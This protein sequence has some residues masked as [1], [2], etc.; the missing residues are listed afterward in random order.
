MG[1]GIIKSHDGAGLYTVEIVIDNTR[2][3]K[4]ID[5]CQ[6]RIENLRELQKPEAEVAAN[7]AESVKNTEFAGLNTAIN[8]WKADPTDENLKAIRDQQAVYQ[9]ALK[10]Y[11]RKR[12]PL[13]LIESRILAQL[14]HFSWLQSQKL[15]NFDAQV[16]SAD[17]IDGNCGGAVHTAGSEVGI[18]EF[19][20]DAD[21][22]RVIQPGFTGGETFDVDRDGNLMPVAV[23]SPAATYYNFAI[24]P[25]WQKWRYEYRVGTI[26]AVG[27]TAGNF[28]VTLDDRKSDQQFPLIPVN[29]VSANDDRNLSDIDVSYMD[30]DAAAF[31]VGDRVVVQ[32][33]KDFTSYPPTIA[34][35]ETIIGFET[36]PKGCLPNGFNYQSWNG[37][38]GPIYGWQNIDDST[39][40]WV[41][42]EPIST[43]LT[44]DITSYN[45]VKSRFWFPAG[46]CS[47][48]DVLQWGWPDNAASYWIYR[49]GARIARAPDVAGGTEII[50]AAMISPD[51]NYLWAIFTIANAQSTAVYVGRK[52]TTAELTGA[53]YDAQTDP[54]GWE[55][56]TLTVDTD[57]LMLEP[58]WSFND[59]CT[60]ARAMCQYRHPKNRTPAVDP[61]VGIWDTAMSY[62]NVWEENQ[63]NIEDP[64]ATTIAAANVT[65]Q[66]NGIIG[67]ILKQVSNLDQR[68][69]WNITTYT[70]PDPDQCYYANHRDKQVQSET[71]SGSNAIRVGWDGT[72]WSYVELEGRG[73]RSYNST[74]EAEYIED[75]GPPQFT[76]TVAGAS[77]SGKFGVWLVIDA[78]NVDVEYAVSE[79]TRAWSW[80]SG[81]CWDSR[82]T[83][84]EHWACEEVF[85]EVESAVAFIDKMRQKTTNTETHTGPNC[86]GT[87]VSADDK[88]ASGEVFLGSSIKDTNEDNT[89]STPGSGAT[90]MA[91]TMSG[92]DTT[93]G[94]GICDD[95][96]P[97]WFSNVN[98]TT[99]YDVTGG[100]FEGGGLSVLPSLENVS[101]GISPGNAFCAAWRQQRDTGSFVY[102]HYLTGGDLDTLS[103]NPGADPFY[104][105]IHPA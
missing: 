13:D 11:I 55:T 62:G 42:T 71:Y 104:R 15:D 6:L 49:N 94:G 27:A 37:I 14:Q 43:D 26:T 65:W 97:N 45:G 25:G 67:R 75:G 73:T 63:V 82:S 32:I 29:T 48:Y 100:T 95:P 4:L 57:N 77:E 70:P 87:Y 39:G 103:G 8:T 18:I 9:K 66:N 19:N 85:T 59:A 51:G 102:E 10:D 61:P 17:L 23:L 56:T 34:V 5:E 78:A 40:S 93:I 79:L 12:T 105:Y 21:F 86:D 83:N 98:T 64:S 91:I 30:C 7:A 20:G 74:I 22:G 84:S 60:E 44:G 33:S 38:G 2:L 31:T 41:M 81:N 54:H 24:F 92:I 96:D 90:T 89:T 69:S 50:G 72:G 16:W 28:D 58:E 76:Y 3:D 1:K 36:S 101:G 68:G 52:T 35:T 46:N 47:N 80:T 53:L 88:Y 99:T